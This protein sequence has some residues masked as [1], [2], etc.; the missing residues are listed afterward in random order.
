MLYVTWFVHV[1]TAL[2]STKFW[3]LYLAVRLALL[4]ELSRGSLT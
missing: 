3:W 4:A 2:I 1:T